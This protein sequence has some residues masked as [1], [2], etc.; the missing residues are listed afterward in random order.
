MQKRP[1]PEIFD[2]RKNGFKILNNSIRIDM[3][4]NKK[5]FYLLKITLHI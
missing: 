3:I 2:S 4:I 5:T 1:D